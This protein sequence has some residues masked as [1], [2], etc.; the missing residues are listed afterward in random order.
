MAVGIDAS[1]PESLTEGEVRCH[2]IVFQIWRFLRETVPGYEKCVPLTIAAYLGVR[3]TRR[4][5]GEYMLTEEDVLSARKFP[6]GIARGSFYM[7]V[8]DGQEKTPQYRAA[9]SPPPGDFYEIPYRCLVPQAVD[10]LLVAGRCISTTRMANG[11]IR[12]QPTCMNTGQA[13]GV[14]A[15]WC[16]R[17]G[18]LPRVVDGVELRAALVTQGMDLQ[19]QPAEA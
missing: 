10:G 9:L 17:R 15:A 5:V 7:D 14:A 1:D 13:A 18:I 4:I 12:I 6:D 3:E 2:E 19:C 8:H 11:S 16:V